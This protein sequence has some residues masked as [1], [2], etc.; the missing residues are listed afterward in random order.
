ML[1]EFDDILMPLI[2]KY[3]LLRSR[4]ARHYWECSIFES[5]ICAIPILTYIST[6]RYEH[7]CELK[8][9]FF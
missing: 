4:T 3:L 5:Q 6:S 7:T 9:R 2:R 8:V 1:L